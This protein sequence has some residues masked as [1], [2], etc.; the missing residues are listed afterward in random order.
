M[1][2]EKAAC[3]GRRQPRAGRG[4][5]LRWERGQPAVAPGREVGEGAARWCKK[6]EPVVGEGAACG[7]CRPPQA[8]PF[9]NLAAAGGGRK[10]A[11]PTRASDRHSASRLPPATKP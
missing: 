10:V 5:S 3:G 1:V 2:G 4:G 7:A 11:N 9:A 8:P 6:G